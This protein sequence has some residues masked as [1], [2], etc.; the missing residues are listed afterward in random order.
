MQRKPRHKG[1]DRHVQ[2]TL[3]PTRQWL[4]RVQHLR[5]QYLLAQ[6]LLW[7]SLEMQVTALS[8]QL[9]VHK[10]L[11]C[12]S[13]IQGPHLMTPHRHWLHDYSKLCVP[14]QLAD[15][16]I[17]YSK[18]IGNVVFNPVISG[19]AVR[20]VE[21]TC[22]LHVPDLQNNLL[23]VLYLSPQH[24]ID[25]HI[26][27]TELAMIFTL[28][29]E[30][31]FIAPI[32]CDNSALLAGSTEMFTGYAHRSILTL[33]PDRNLWH[34]R[35]GHH[36]HDVVNKIA[37]NKLATGMHINMQNAPNLICEP[38]LAGKMNAQ[39][40]GT[41]A[42]CT[43]NPLDLIHTNL[44]G[45]FRTVTHLGCRYWIIFI[46]DNTCFR[47]IYFLCTKD[48]AFEAFKLFK[49]KAEN[50]WSRKIKAMID[51]K[52]GEYMSKKFLTFTDDCGIKHLHTVC[53]RPQQNGTSE[54]AN[55]TIAEHTTTVLYEAG[56]PPTFLGE[57]ADTYVSVQN[58]CPT[59]ALT[60]KTPFELWHGWKPDISNLRVW[61][62]SAYV[63]IQKDKRVG[64]NSH[65]ERCIFIGY[66]EGYKAWKFYNPTTW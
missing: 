22:V 4:V 33:A 9:L 53:N 20:P 66:P 63:H 41:S 45:P 1:R 32:N 39:P 35:L 57:A 43:E 30:R 28:G 40:F 11:T 58:K 48:Q 26:S 51:N 36:G 2:P 52:G 31:L 38:C 56:L 59:N 62:C 12:G 10:T 55:R 16:T 6:S 15:N 65:M 42:S 34:R 17:V 54:R 19:R 25:I 8:N 7:N 18:G 46:D 24:G 44:H 47:A 50:H 37:R 14:I 64:I 23:A 29:H 5:Q 60:G 61:G 21:F 49:A 27:S 3:R 13:Q